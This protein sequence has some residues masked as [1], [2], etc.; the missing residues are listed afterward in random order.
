MPL[1]NL[2]L[3]G[4]SLTRWIVAVAASA[5][6]YS[7]LL[8]LRRIVANRLSRFAEH[9]RNDWDDLIV[10]MIRRTRGITLLVASVWPALEILDAT[11]GIRNAV[12]AATVVIVGFQIATWGDLIITKVLQH[13][14]LRMQADDPAAAGTL[15]GL[16]VLFRGLLWILLLL[17]AL[18]NLGVN[19]SALVATLGIGGVAIALATQNIL[20]DLFGSL[21]IVLDKPFVVGDFIVVQDLSGTVEH[22][23]LKTTR[24]RS[25]SGEQLVF[26]NADLLTSR[27]HN[28]KRMSER[29][30]VFTV[31]VTYQTPSE[32]LAEIP[33]MLQTIMK[34]AEGVRIERVHLKS[35]DAGQV[36]F[37]VVYIVLTSDYNHYMDI[38]QKINLAI[39][40]RFEEE[41]IDFAS[42][43]VSGLNRNAAAKAS[44][45]ETAGSGAR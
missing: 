14:V 23:G 1:D 12:W 30:V 37:E 28:Y 32:T 44:A 24:L 29:R 4:I 34:S 22:I 33:G 19:I 20:G 2:L 15:T 18:D 6:I 3:L 36:T 5:V 38:Q 9:T 27:V 17:L 25:L 16:T 41:G 8:L 7:L 26:S 40:R 35:F 39:Y 13:R 42:P 31:G 21:S 11:P 43:F 45:T 10:L